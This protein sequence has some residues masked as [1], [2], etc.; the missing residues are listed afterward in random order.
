MFVATSCM[1]QNVL[2]QKRQ[3]PCLL[4]STKPCNILVDPICTATR[5]NACIIGRGLSITITGSPT[6]IRTTG[7][8]GGSG[9]DPV[10]AGPGCYI[11]TSPPD[12]R[13]VTV[14]DSCGLIYDPVCDCFNAADIVNNDK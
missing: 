6:R 4:G 11:Y 1:A 5:A 9:N 13:T 12:N 7:L 2:I 10:V 8:L 14:G 3:S